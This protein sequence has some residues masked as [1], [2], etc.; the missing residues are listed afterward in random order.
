MR[1]TEVEATITQA[2]TVLKEIAVTGERARGVPKG[3]VEVLDRCGVVVGGGA[4]A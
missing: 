3:A 2:Q 4:G 1:K